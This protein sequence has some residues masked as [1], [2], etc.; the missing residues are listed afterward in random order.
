MQELCRTSQTGVLQRG[1]LPPYNCRECSSIYVVLAHGLSLERRQD[2]MI[3][4]GDPTGTG[5][6][7]TSIYGQ[8][9]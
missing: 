4:S 9:L 6:G 5:R 8:K 1:R 7:G 3:Q 2:F